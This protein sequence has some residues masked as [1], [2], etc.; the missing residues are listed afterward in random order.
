MSDESD[1]SPVVKS[2]RSRRRRRWMAY[3]AGGALAATGAAITLGPAAPWVVDSLDGQRVWRLGR[4]DIDGVSGGWL[5]A[6]RAEHISIA[7]EDG[8]WLEAENVALRWRPQD[9]LFG[10][11][12]I[13]SAYAASVRVLRQPT[14]LERRPSSGVDFDVWIGSLRTESITLEQAVV[15]EAAAFEAALSLDL[16]KR[17]LEGL[18]LALRRTDSEADRIIAVYRPDEDYALHVDVIS[19]PGGILAR[20][21]GVA[22]EGVRAA[23]NGVGDAQ[24][25][26][27]TYSATIGET[28][29]LTGAARW[30]PARWSTQANA[31][32]DLLPALRT[33]GRRIGASAAVEASGERVGDFTAH[34]ETP[35]LALDISGELDNKR[36]LVGGARFVATT[37]RLSDIAREAPFAFGA[38]RLQGELR[39]A[40]GAI[41]IQGE[42]DAQEIEAL[43]QRTRLTG[44]VRA[45]LNDRRF[46]LR[47]DLRA[48]QDAPPAFAGARLTTELH[49]DRDRRRFELER[50]AL[51]GEAIEVDAQGW[52]TRGD[53]EFSGAWRVRR[54]AAFASELTGGASGRWRAF[55]ERRETARVW[56][57]SVRGA[58][59]EIGGAP[60]IVP[61]LLGDAPRLDARMTYENG[62]TTVSYARLEGAQL[63]AAARGRIVRGQADLAL[64]ASARGPLTVGGAE[65]AGAADLTGQIT[66][67]LARPTLSA[68]ASLASFSAGGVVVTQPV[69][70]FTLAPSG[71]G[72]AGRASVSGAASGQPLTAAAN[73]GVAGG[74]ISLTE[75]DGQIAAM[76]AR[77]SAVFTPRGASAELDVD[78]A[79]DGLV[80][81]MTGRMVGDLSLTPEQ[82]VLAAQITD[83]RAGELRVRAATLRARGP[84]DAIAAEFD[85]R[86]RLG[87]APLSFAGTSTVD[88]SGDATGIVI[89]GRGVLA[90][91]DVFTRAPIRARLERGRTTA[92]LSV[93]LGDGVVTAEWEERGRALSGTA[94]IDHAPL[95]PLAAIWGER[96][97]GRIDGR[98][99]LANVG[100]GL[101]GDADLTLDGARFAGRQRGRLDMRIVGDL[102]PRRLRATVDARS[103][104]GLQARFEADAPVV[105]SAAPIRIALAPERRGRATWRVRGPAESLWAATRLQDQSLSGQLDGEGELAFGAGYL[106]GA[107]HIEIVDGRFEDKL[108]GVTLADLDA[109]IA[110][111]D[112]GVTIENFTA[113]GPRGGR[114]RATGGSA[115]PREGR[116]AVTVEE[117][118]IAD[119]PDARARAS[120][121]LTL[122]WEGLRAQLTGALN[123]IEADIDV[124][125]NADAGIPTLD[126]IEINRPGE[127]DEE[128]IP[129]LPRRTLTATEIDVR[130]TAPGRVFT[131]GRGLDAEWA[132]DLRLQGTSRDP[133]LFGE[134]R[135]VRGTLALSGQP[136]EIENARIVF[137]GDPMDAEI[138]LLARRDGAD[139]TAY[140]RLT[141]TARDPEVSLT[142][143]PGLPEDEILPQVLFGRSVEDLSALEAAQLAASLAT[144]SGR[145]SLD[146]VDAA[147]AAAGLDRFNVRQ[148]ENGG[149]LV[150]GGVYLTR[151]VYLEVARTGL[152]EAQTRVEWTLRPRLVLITS[153]LSD[154]EQRVSLRWR[155]ESD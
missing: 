116:I 117:M 39:R 154:G 66:G 44:Q 145:A 47:G 70:Q 103:T 18:D 80:P 10:A 112:R 150:A 62:G 111:D 72:Y 85:M 2:N 95:T 20:A 29:L 144:L 19:A 146:L 153:F 64:E 148:D 45:A 78:G 22:D 133:R 94:R 43:G 132:L 120:G 127:E 108:T 59:A 16:R 6:L 65:I 109:R 60:A 93:A 107:G 26:E 89:E 135:A 113:A 48:P 34:A 77:G 98:I 33:L 100:G 54:L 63:R 99:G 51:S 21:L 15:G 118:R 83:A 81:G 137:N 141:G 136:F 25:G 90:E 4:I 14:L 41:A 3:A 82:L 17:S 123:I 1:L 49:Y 131:R 88:A 40:R 151:D 79:L 119:R 76:R 155:R 28:P 42:L 73:V 31:R 9:I 12:R 106:S 56:T 13:D 105:T 75:L 57:T 87:R 8:V 104:E 124:A 74:A 129:E 140:V 11:V 5:G 53:G 126:V 32:F 115:N 27:A 110:I 142:S 36:E 149:F 37:T 96:A 55:A 128:Q 143:D 86:G 122:E 7:D 35:F 46:E 114:L 69:V 101:S 71:R 130:I 50:A 152:G 91:S 30:T 38:A 102:D 92:S 68:H 138:D 24:A 52:A 67:R 134:A 121:E 147:R 61:Q 58:G 84:F 23:A 139:L 97:E 125:A